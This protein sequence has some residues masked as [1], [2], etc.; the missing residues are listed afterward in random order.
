LDLLLKVKVL[1]SE[2]PA[3]V[4]VEIKQLINREADLINR[5]RPATNLVGV[6]ERILKLFLYYVQN[7]NTNPEIGLLRL[8]K[9]R[10]QKLKTVPVQ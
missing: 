8:R 3:D 7:E 6:R 2:K 9:L 10:A 5:G 4:S 1:V